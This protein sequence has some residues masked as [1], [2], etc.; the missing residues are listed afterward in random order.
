MI[1][2]IDYRDTSGVAM[3]R[4]IKGEHTWLLIAKLAQ[5]MASKGCQISRIEIIRFSTHAKEA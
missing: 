1:W 4:I 3:R 5:N 2:A